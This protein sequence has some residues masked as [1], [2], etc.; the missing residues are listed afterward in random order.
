MLARRRALPPEAAR[1]AARSAERHL[2]G[3]AELLCARR[4]ALYAAL[5]DEIATAGLFHGL[6]KA[7][8]VCLLPRVVAGR[9]LAFCAVERW[10]DLVPGSFGVS[11][12]PE[13]CPTIRPGPGDVVIAPGVA[14]DAEGWRLGWGG[15]HYD[16]AFPPEAA[17]APLLFGL[18]FELQVVES[19]PHGSRDRRMDAIV[20][21]RGIRSVTRV[22]P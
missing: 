16:R 17:E 11:E 18:A 9:R 21:E 7:G 4:V 10:E 19:V 1:A 12:P 22:A 2:L 8:K 5:A 3:A 20:T 13:G 14:F 15:G 6:A